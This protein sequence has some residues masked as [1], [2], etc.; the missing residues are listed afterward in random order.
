M[1]AQ[2]FEH[3]V[4]LRQILTARAL[5]LEEIGHRVQP[6]AVHAEV[7]P[8][9]QHLHHLVIDLRI[10]PVQVRLVGEKAVPEIRARHIVAVQFESS[11]SLKMIR[12]SLYF[13]VV[14]LH[15]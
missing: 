5:A 14:S 12:V 6:Q 11:M 10:V 3:R 8:E 15:T 4:G 1:F 13:S 7:E 9:I 2:P